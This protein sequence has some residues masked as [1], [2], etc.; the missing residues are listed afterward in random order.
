M[1]AEECDLFDQQSMV[2]LVVLNLDMKDTEIPLRMTK[3]E[4]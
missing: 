3:T 4:E 1:T 2:P